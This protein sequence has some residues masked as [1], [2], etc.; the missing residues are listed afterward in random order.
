MDHSPLRKLAPELRNAIWE[1]VLKRERFCINLDRSSKKPKLKYDCKGIDET[2]CL[3]SLAKT[4][5]A[6]HHESLPLLYG[7]NVF[8][9]EIRHEN[10]QQALN[11]FFE[12]RSGKAA[13]AIS[14][15]V[16]QQFIDGTKVGSQVQSTREIQRK[17]RNIKHL[18]ASVAPNDRKVILD[19]ECWAVNWE[20]SW[21]L[22]KR[23]MFEMHQADVTCTKIFS[24]IE[25]YTSAAD[26]VDKKENKDA[27]AA[28]NDALDTTNEGQEAARMTMDVEDL[29]RLT[30]KQA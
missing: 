8:R 18:L 23:F 1:L 22:K 11:L 16:L 25:P 26:P 9:F 4:C 6:L 15:I 27:L 30:I 20:S 13:A 5:R 3:T 24:T 14:H 29:F 12:Q 21:E 7:V 2:R 10:A 28:L 19:F 17:F